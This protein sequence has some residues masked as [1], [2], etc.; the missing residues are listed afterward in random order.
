MAGCKETND[1]SDCGVICFW[2]NGVC[3]LCTRSQPLDGPNRYVVVLLCVGVWVVFLSSK[4]QCSYTQT[5]T[6]RLFC[7]VG[8]NVGIIGSTYLIRTV[9]K[10]ERSGTF[11][12]LNAFANLGLIFGPAL[13]LGLAQI[14]FWKLGKHFSV[15]P[16]SSPGWFMLLLLSYCIFITLL[17][18]KEPPLPPLKEEEAKE[19]EEEERTSWLMKSFRSALKDYCSILNLTTVTLCF[20]NFILVFNQTCLETI[21][22]PLSKLVFE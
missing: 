19:E 3:V 22:T 20:G 17:M 4:P 15:D 6:A 2:N 7:G 13:N 21:L 18:F 12:A 10:E 9:V 1:T 5:N 16:Y 8:A 14:P 11:A